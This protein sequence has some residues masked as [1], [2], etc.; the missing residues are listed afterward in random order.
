MVIEYKANIWLIVTFN[1]TD[2]F[3]FTNENYKINRD[4]NVNVAYYANSMPT[5]ISDEIIWCDESIEKWFNSESISKLKNE[6]NKLIAIS[7][8]ILTNCSLKDVKSYWNFL[9]D[10]GFDGICTNFPKD[11]K[12]FFLGLG[13][14]N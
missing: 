10:L 8:E 9:Y 13:E 7:Q 5:D 6:N 11:C 14:K 12:S 4:E 2:F 3:L 1:I